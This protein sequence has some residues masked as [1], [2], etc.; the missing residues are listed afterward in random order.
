MRHHDLRMHKKQ[1]AQAQMRK[2]MDKSDYINFGTAIHPNL[3]QDS[4]KT[5]NKVGGR[6]LQHKELTK[7]CFLNT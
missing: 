2:K 5:S 3:H 6:Y 7:I 1:N 4:L